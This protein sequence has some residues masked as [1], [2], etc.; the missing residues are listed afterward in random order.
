MQ[1]SAEIVRRRNSGHP[2]HGCIIKLCSLE[3]GGLSPSDL[4]FRCQQA[5]GK[6]EGSAL[7]LTQHPPFYEGVRG[8]GSSMVLASH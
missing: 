6:D 5:D 1:C 8:V 7:F 2:E 4:P 3:D